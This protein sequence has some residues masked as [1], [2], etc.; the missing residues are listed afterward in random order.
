[1]LAVGRLIS[2]NAPY[3]TWLQRR[4]K[5]YSSREPFPSDQK[6]LEDVLKVVN[7]KL[8]YASVK[9]ALAYPYSNGRVERHVNRLKTIKR[10]MYG[11]I[12]IGP[13]TGIVRHYQTSAY[14][15]THNKFHTSPCK[16]HRT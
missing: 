9:A 10:M 14:H 8:D 11:R 13:G 7:I 12:L 4:H 1:M 3:L 15:R 6:S 5:D 2:S 16:L